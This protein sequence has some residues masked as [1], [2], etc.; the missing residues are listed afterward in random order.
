MFKPPI[1]L[2]SQTKI[3]KDKKNSI[4]STIQKEE[5]TS[6]PLSP[7][8]PQTV[9]ELY[10]NGVSLYMDKKYEDAAKIFDRIYQ[11]D[12]NFID[13]VRFKGRS[14]AALNR[15]QAAVYY[16]DHVLNSNPNDIVVLFLMAN[17]LLALNR[18]SEALECYEKI[19]RIQPENRVAAEKKAS[20][21]NSL[22]KG[23]GIKFRRSKR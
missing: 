10:E 5:P 8:S 9:S 20:L 12:P 7:A 19:I 22:P 23:R 1:T 15:H 11:M 16:F 4:S 21:Q 3:K 14:L 2:K 13:A 18:P 6:V 17:S